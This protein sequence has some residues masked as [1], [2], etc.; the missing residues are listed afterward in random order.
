MSWRHLGSWL[1]GGFFQQ[2]YGPEERK[3]A[4]NAFGNMGWF[5]PVQQPRYWDAK[6]TGIKP[7]LYRAPMTDLPD[8]PWRTGAE[9]LADAFLDYLRW[10]RDYGGLPRDGAVNLLADT[11]PAERADGRRAAVRTK[12][13]GQTTP[14]S[15]V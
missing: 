1:L 4:M 6:Q 10:T 12:W 9:T 5:C 2:V 15:R 8:G 13:N 11:P 14:P 7:D 3:G